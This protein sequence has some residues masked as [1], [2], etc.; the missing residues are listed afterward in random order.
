MCWRR[1]MEKRDTLALIR[2]YL[3]PRHNRFIKLFHQKSGLAYGLY[4]TCTRV[5]TGICPAV[6]KSLMS[7]Q[8]EV[9]SVKSKFGY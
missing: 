5:Q 6:A 1:L 4:L 9:L 3:Y 7:R 2:G 8:K